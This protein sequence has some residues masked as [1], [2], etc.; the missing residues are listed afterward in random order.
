M[1]VSI[2]RKKRSPYLQVDGAARRHWQA[3]VLLLIIAFGVYINLAFFYGA[4]WINGS[5][6]YIY[7]SQ[8][9]AFSQGHFHQG[10]C[11][12][13]DCVNYIVT[14][15]EA[16]FLSLFGLSPLTAS[17]FGLLCLALTIVVLYLIGRQVSSPVAGLIAGF[18]YVLFPVVSTQTS[19][20]GDDIPMVLFVSASALLIILAFA[21]SRSKG[22]QRLYFTLA[23]FV[24]MIA[25]LTISE[26]I[27]GTIT[28][29][30]FLLLN[31]LYRRK[32][33][34]FEAFGLF[35]AGVLL[36]FAVI[37]L[38]GIY[39][40]NSPM[41]VFNVY[42]SNFA[43][44]NANPIAFSKYLSDMFLPGTSMQY[45]ALA[46]GYLGLAFLASAVYLLVTRY[47]K[48]AFIG[49][50]FLFSFL[51]LS[52]GTES[53][54]TYSPVQ[55]LNPYQVRFALVLIPAMSLLIG[56]AVAR[57]PSS[58]RKHGIPKLITYSALA[59]VFLVIATVSINY[60]SYLNYIQL[61]SIAP[62][63]QINQYLQARPAGTMV[64]G[65]V[66]VPW[67]AYL[68][69]NVEAL[70][71]SRTLGTCANVTSMFKISAGDYFVGN[72]TDPSACSLKIVFSPQE[73]SQLERYA[74]GLGAD[75]YAINVYRYEPT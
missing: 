7:L 36:A 65:P 9:Y 61:Y 3:L 59:A 37:A 56:I 45:N 35:C 53:L 47:S 48:A 43:S 40:A 14:L 26:A 6:N 62:L 24:S 23:G 12:I 64:F 71:Y 10:G 1:W 27:I 21:S 66:D 34:A 55:Y 52:F 44:Y 22:R 67:S 18:V 8:A 16:P 41:F 29:F 57:L 39:Q 63:L 51:Y 50:W 4:S 5:D 49:F 72:V 58:L 75:F 32:R 30:A 73:P 46:F 13:V 42:T 33:E 60:I 74:P 70:A 19:N 31:A 54:T 20:V 17:F 68:T 25:F 69:S 2:L 15:G 11:A 38:I 28:F